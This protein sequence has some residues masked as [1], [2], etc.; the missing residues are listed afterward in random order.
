MKILYTSSEALPYASTGGLGD[1][2]GALPPS[3][4][5]ALGKGA[6]IRVVIPLYPV[7]KE[8]YSDILKLECE[9]EVPLSWRRQYCG[10]WST[11]RD[12]VTFY[13]LDNEFYFKREQFYGSYDD[14]ER[15][16]FFGKAVLEMMAHVGFYPDILHANDWQSALCV[17]YLKRKYRYIP[18]YSKIKTVYTIHNIE[19]QGIYGFEILGDVFDLSEWD[20]TT[21]EFDGAINLTKGALTVSDYV[22]TVS[23]TYAREILT[24][25]Y[26]HGLSPILERCKDKLGGI[27]NGIDIDYYNPETDKA[28]RYH[29][30]SEKLEG[31]ARNKALLQEKCGFEKDR[32]IP[33]VAMVSRLAAHKGFDLVSAVIEEILTGDNCQIVLLGTGDGAFENYFK[34]LGEKY[35]DRFCAMIKFD[36]ELSKLIYAGADIFLMPSKSEPCGL[37]QM[38]ASRYG[39]VPVVRETG[40]L[41]DTIRAYN[42]FTKEG[43]GFS[44][45]NYNAH[46]MM[47][48]VREA[49][50]LYRD[51]RSWNKLVRQVMKVDFSWKCS[52]EKYVDLYK[53]ITLSE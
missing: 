3:V 38:I 4:A 16:A 22:T 14:G 1:V 9:F 52:A 29:Y 19:Y 35:P 47:A 23:E 21:V 45:S 28:L 51:K 12:G 48:A 8:K 26:S 36:K 40:G 33:V 42:K 24:P 2:I 44:F 39:A 20:R 32:S 6:D 49:F 7:V 43:N 31:K 25:Y 15:F 10:V 17:I 46:E 11:K 53:K 5:K 41:Y 30:T 18:E 37:S 34:R 27:V 13:F 50:K